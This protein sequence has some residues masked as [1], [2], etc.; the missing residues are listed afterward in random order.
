MLPI[1]LP[2]QPRTVG[3]IT[4]KNWTLSPLSELFIKCAREM[5]RP[6]AAAKTT[7]R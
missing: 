3:I 5:V 2:V 1:K 6:D 7:P 4:L